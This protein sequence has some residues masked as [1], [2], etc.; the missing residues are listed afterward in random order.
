MKA[1]TIKKRIEE[2]GIKKKF[3][4]KEI[5]ISDVLLSYYLN[6]K[7][8]MPEHIKARIRGFLKV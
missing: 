5:G 3:I 7:R 2:R 4:A 8:K 1:I 6:E